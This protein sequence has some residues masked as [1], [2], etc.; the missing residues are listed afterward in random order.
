MKGFKLPFI[1]KIPV[2]IENEINKDVERDVVYSDLKQKTLDRLFNNPKSPLRKVGDYLW[3]NYTKGAISYDEI[4]KVLGM[5]KEVVIQRVSQLN[6]YN[7]FPLT[8]MPVPKMKGYIQSVLNN[9]TDYDNWD[10][11]KQ[12]TIVSMEQ[13]RGKAKKTTRAKERTKKQQKQKVQNGTTNN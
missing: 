8:M 2:E 13:V 12:R 7:K 5:S 4:A 1:S 6:F 11:K 9:D 3:L 10:L